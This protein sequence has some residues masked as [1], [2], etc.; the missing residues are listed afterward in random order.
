MATPVKTG[1]ASSI[2]MIFMVLLYRD[3]VEHGFSNQES[4]A[5]RQRV[6]SNNTWEIIGTIV[7]VMEPLMKGVFLSQG[8]DWLLSEAVARVVK[9]Y[10]RYKSIASETIEVNTSAGSST[11]QIA[12]YRKC[13]AEVL[14]GSLRSVIDPL[15]SA[16]GLN[17]K[18]VHYYLS[19]VLDP[20]YKSRFVLRKQ[21]VFQRVETPNASAA[22]M[23]FGNGKNHCS[24]VRRG[25]SSSCSYIDVQK[26]KRASLWH[27]V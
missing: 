25:C 10:L 11:G 13:L 21:Y 14:R 7:S 8:R 18:F 12:F 6:P 19:I 23:Q 9:L 17:G 27:R 5:L 2:E 16:R 24:K 22:R 1:F 20:N 15:L 4:I 3:V 26:P